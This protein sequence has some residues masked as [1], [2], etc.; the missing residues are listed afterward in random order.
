MVL[1]A[2][3][4]RIPAALME[5]DAHLGL[6]E[7]PARRPFAQRG[8]SVP[9]SGPRAAEVPR[10]RPADPGKLAA[11]SAGRGPAA[12]R[13]PAGRAGAARR[14]RKP[15]ARCAERSRGR[16]L[17]PRRARGAAPRAAS[18]ST[19]AARARVAAGLQAG[20][21]H[22]P[23]RRCARS[24]RP[25]ALARGRRTVWELAAAGKPAI[26]VPYPAATADHQTKNARYFETAGGAIVVPETEL[27]RVPE[28]VRSLLGDARPARGDGHGDATGGAAGGGR[29]RSPRS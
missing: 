3:R 15:G 26:L 2:A 14:R 5:A 22:R 27:G 17:R 29:A 25:R 13:A 4:R 19:T 9:D 7:P 20:A 8:S 24:S 10:H 6:A 11:R 18:G 12:V 1:A 16:E 21:V 23:F 28:I